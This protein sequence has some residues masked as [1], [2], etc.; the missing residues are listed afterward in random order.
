MQRPLP[1]LL[2]A[3]GV[4]ALGMSARPAEARRMSLD[5]LNRI[6]AGFSAADQFTAMGGTIGLDSRL[7]RLV[8]VDVGVFM[9]G[10][11]PAQ[12]TVDEST[13]PKTWFELRHGVYVTPGLRI[14]HRYQEKGLNWDV[15][16]RAGM[17]A[18][19]AHDPSQTTTD[20]RA[21]HIS[22]PAA[23]FGADALVRWDRV[24][25]RVSGKGFAW[26]SYQPVVQES[27]G[28]VRPQVAV[29]G[30]FQW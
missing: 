24:G 15:I 29:E 7:T 2:M 11:D 18:V 9:S 16:G 1:R 3:A 20:G 10:T 14:P 5:P 26:R 17:G 4:L 27:V 19:W 21:V 30:V 28:V 6:H 22:E 13:D 23:V 8:F 25:L 12:T